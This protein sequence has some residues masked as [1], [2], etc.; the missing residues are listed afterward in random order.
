MFKTTF[1]ITRTKLQVKYPPRQPLRG[2]NLHGP[3]LRNLVIP[4]A[5]VKIDD[6][7]VSMYNELSFPVRMFSRHNV[8]PFCSL[9]D[10]SVSTPIKM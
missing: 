6:I 10:L 1:I 5:A 9:Q 8:M 2:K 7:S 3:S 4:N